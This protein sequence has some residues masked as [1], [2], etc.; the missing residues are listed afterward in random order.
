ME[1]VVP[2][3]LL[4]ALLLLS[5]L[6]LSLFNPVSSIAQRKYNNEWIDYSKT[7]YKFKI[8]TTGVYRISQSDLNAIGLGSA[9]P[10]QLQL[11][12]NGEQ[13]PL[14]VNNQGGTFQYVE[15][16]GKKNDGKP[17]KALYKNPAY[18]FSDNNS[19]IT[20]TAT[21][22]FTVNT[23]TSQNVRFVD[24]TNTITG[25]VTAE[26]YFIHTERVSKGT[27]KVSMSYGRGGYS[28]G[29]EFFY[30]SNYDEGEF[31]ISNYVPGSNKTGVVNSGAILYPYTNSGA[32]QATVRAGL[33]EVSVSNTGNPYYCGD[34]YSRNYTVIVNGKNLIR[35]SLDYSGFSTKID[36]SFINLDTVVTNNSPVSF[37]INNDEPT[38]HLD[39]AYLAY[40]FVNITYPRLFDFGGDSSF[41]FTLPA[42]SQDFYLQISDFKAGASVAPVLY[43]FTNGIRYTADLS[44]ANYLQFE[45]PPSANSRNLL[46]VSEDNSQIHSINTAAVV[47][48]NFTNYSNSANQADYLIISNQILYNGGPQVEQYR[49]YRAS[50]AGGGYNA[51]IFDID[52]IEDQ[53]AFGI[54]KHPISVKNFLRYARKNFSTAPQFVFIIGN[55]LQYMDYYTNQSAPY[56]DALNL[57]PTFGWPA[58]DI[59]LSSDSTDAIAATP[60]GRLAVVNPNEITSYL[61]KVI[62]YESVQNDTTSPT[63]SK[64]YWMKNVLHLSGTTDP[65][66]DTRFTSY[67]NI[68]RSFIMDSSYGGNVTTINSQTANSNPVIA[69]EI[70]NGVG[71]IGYIGHAS[72]ATLSYNLNSPEAFTNKGKY[73]IFFIGGCNSGDVFSYSP[74]R[75]IN[76]SSLPEKYIL[77]PDKGSVAF[78]ANTYIGYESFITVYGN[79]FYKSISRTNYGSSVFNGMIAGQRAI[80]D[81]VRTGLIDTT[82][83]RSQGEQCL[84]LGDPALK[85]NTFSYPDFAVQDSLIKITPADISASDSSF[86]IK[87]YMYNLGKYAGDSLLVQVKQQYPNGNTAI[88]LSKN[89]P[90][91][92]YMDSIQLN[93]PIIM[94]RDTGNNYI[95]VTV[96]PNNKYTELS[97]ANNSATVLVVVNK[98]LINP[99]FPYNYAI[100]NRQGI[101]LKASTANPLAAATNYTLEVD[102]TALFNSA[103]KISQTINSIGGVVEFN[104]GITFIDSTVY[105][106]RVGAVSSVTGAVTHWRNSSFVYLA[107]AISDGWNQSHLYQNLQ[108][109]VA[110][111]YL[112][113]NSREWKFNRNT[114]TMSVQQGIYGTSIYGISES[115]IK[116]NNATASVFCND[117]YG[118]SIVFSVHDPNSLLPLYNQ[119]TP[120]TVSDGTYSSRFMGSMVWAS[121]SYNH[122]GYR[123]FEF[124]YTSP[125]NRD[126]IAKFLNW[127]P[128]GDYVTARIMVSSSDTNNVYANV[129][130]N[131]PVTAPYGNMYQQFVNA[132][133][134][135]IDSFYHARTWVFIFKKG[136]NSYNPIIQYS[137]GVYDKIAFSTYLP[138]SDTLGYIT[139]P[140]YGPATSWSNLEWRG[141]SKVSPATS[142]PTIDIIGV[143]VNGN[144]TV[145]NTIDSTQ[146]N[147]SLSSVSASNYPYLQL[148]MR[149][150]DSI[151]YTP[152]QLKYWRIYYT[153]VPE[154][155][156]AGNLNV[157]LPDSVRANT[158][159]NGTIAFK[160]VSNVPFASPISVNVVIYDSLNVGHVIQ[161]NSLPA[162]NPNDTANITL[163]IPA[164]GYKG[165]NLLYVEV[166]PIVS[167]NTGTNSNNSN[168]V[169]VAPQT[170][171]PEQYHLN[172]FLYKYI[173]VTNSISLPVN[174]TSFTGVINNGKSVL[175]WQTSAETNNK[176]FQIERSVNN[177]PFVNIGTVN[178]SGS[179]NTLH[180]Y[181]Y[182]D[183]S[184]VVGAVNI[185]RLSQVDIGGAVNPYNKYISLNYGT[186]NQY[187]L[188]PNPADKEI[189]ITIPSTLTGNAT[190]SIFDASGRKVATRQY[191]LQGNTIN[192]NI[193]GLV[194]GIYFVVLQTSDGGIQRFRF[195]KK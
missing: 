136:D 39:A 123:N 99:V 195:V 73:P 86:Q 166:N 2:K 125:A 58:S 33:A 94:A 51:K 63:I 177:Q 85:L 189:N 128:S 93:V 124:P 60:I 129:W 80:V 79:S 98:D 12:R 188:F 26:P 75:L 173:T 82:S 110:R 34:G 23:N 194:S 1:K 117:L 115:Q 163:S 97:K 67:L 187:S 155:A 106:W 62:A 164:A 18:Q 168:S 130:K 141:Y 10:S 50:T 46:L 101:T 159:Y 134:S 191:V 64:K 171:Q 113:S 156:L 3:R 6:A 193:Q 70:D 143:D 19:I 14:Y 92:Q 182:I 107:N 116:V 52:Q 32:P 42:K 29:G 184:P 13:V 132:G 160:N 27:D 24:G 48:R 119:A 36:S 118:G 167:N 137:Q 161:T 25:T 66:E 140:L 88:L 96:D 186:N 174:I 89:I 83:A 76:I 109:S 114:G 148:R 91:I 90:A 35:G 81:T 108:S 178:G 8:G 176:Y 31:F 53:F 41:Y 154:G 169:A 102:T 121:G 172:N 54:K 43:D 11:W 9:D 111:I 71:L 192:A 133:F 190:L 152:Y 20:D 181:E 127:V 105:Y 158:N 21:F 40:N 17:D 131:D 165:K 57:V 95:T 142:K 146:Q 49:Q 47:T 37:A 61:N 16:W 28:Y 183:Q 120:S 84:L 104:P 4:I 59:L 149:N 126:T 78:M 135:T 150:C 103:F 139:S 151:N 55:G 144:Q 157:S 180:S 138:M 145:L 74:S 170:V 44:N 112:D 175:N 30:S 68:Y 45:L 72:S 179:T 162:L 100:V 122:A 69:N 147:Y 38:S 185:Y 5:C 22:F 87:A 56:A 7:Y 15:F 153:P 77:L 65:S